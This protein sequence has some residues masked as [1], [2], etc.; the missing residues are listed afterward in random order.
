MTIWPEIPRLR[1]QLQRGFIVSSTRGTIEMFACL[2]QNSSPKILRGRC[3]NCGFIT[4]T[5]NNRISCYRFEELWAHVIVKTCSDSFLPAD[6]MQ[7]P[8]ASNVNAPYFDYSPCL[9]SYIL[10]ASVLTAKQSNVFLIVPIRSLD[11]LDL[12][13]FYSNRGLIRAGGWVGSRVSIA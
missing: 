3:P 11:Q 2:S 1:R 4:A 9:L 8:I 12:I 13:E 6:L 5:V 7:E 10:C